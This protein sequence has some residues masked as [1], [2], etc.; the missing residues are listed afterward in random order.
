MLQDKMKRWDQR[1]ANGNED[2]WLIVSAISGSLIGL[3]LIWLS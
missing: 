3:V 1:Q 2:T